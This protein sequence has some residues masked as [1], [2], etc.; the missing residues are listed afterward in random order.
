MPTRN[1]DRAWV[2]LG[3]CPMLVPAT[4]AVSGLGLALTTCVVMLGSVATLSVV[5][6]AITKA[7][8]SIIVL[9][10]AGGFCACAVSVMRAFAFGL[11]EHVALYAQIIAVNRLLHTHLLRMVSP[12]PALRAAADAIVSA[13]MFAGL[14]V[15]FGAIRE[16][17]GRGTLFAGME[18]L[19]GEGAAAWRVELAPD[20]ALALLVTPAGAFLCA[21]VLLACHRAVTARRRTSHAS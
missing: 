6:G 20:H 8:R 5:R 9:L 19:F 3:F 12:L 1:D 7:P 16:G 13:L 11:W 14:L 2:L 17:F 15:V 4:S 18:L 21:G 10:V